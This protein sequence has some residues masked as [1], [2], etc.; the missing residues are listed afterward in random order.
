MNTQPLSVAHLTVGENRGAP[1]IWLEGKRLL[2]A[3]FTRGAKVRATTHDDAVVLTLDEAGDRTVSG[4]GERPIIDVLGKAV[5]FA[6]NTSIEV[7][8]RPGQ[9]Q[10]RVSPREGAVSRRVARLAAKVTQGAALAVASLCIGAGI[11]DAAISDGMAASGVQVHHELVVEREEAYLDVAIRNHQPTTA[12]HADVSTVDFH[13]RRPVD[14]LVAG[15]PC[16][17]ASRP[18]RAKQRSMDASLTHPEGHPEGS[19]FFDFLRAVI[20]LEP[21]VVVL[22]NVP[23]YR[24]TAGYAAIRAVLGKLSYHVTDTVLDA[25]RWGVNERRERLVMVGAPFPVDLSN[26]APDAAAR[27][28]RT[29]LDDVQDRW[30][31]HARFEQRTQEKLA[32]GA[33]F[34]LQ[35]VTSDDTTVGTIGRGY[36]KDR[37]TEPHILHPTDNRLSRL[38]TVPEHARI[39]GVPEHLVDGL[40]FTIGHEALGQSI[41][42]PPFVS[43][44]R[45]IG[46]T[47]VAA[48]RQ[49]LEIAA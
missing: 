49:Q 1:R 5:P 34:K 38:L 9:I 21:A 19:L 23:L 46:E 43:V 27:P 45:R 16:T 7:T 32:A 14:M 29:V 24:D 37:M 28:L 3:G 35:L 36:S 22:E 41:A 47:I 17:A 33:G 39:K 20:D 6:S 26:L 4:K 42:Y 40:G 18:G 31:P 44:G 2:E 13:N 11:L 15:I 48:Y 10:I 8:Y 25:A 30:R 12:I